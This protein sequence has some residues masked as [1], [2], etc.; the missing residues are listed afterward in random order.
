TSSSLL[1]MIGLSY[2]EFLLS[3]MEDIEQ[4]ESAL[5]FSVLHSRNELWPLL[6]TAQFYQI[7]NRVEAAH[8]YYR[9]ILS[10][11]PRDPS[12]FSSYGFF[13]LSQNKEEVL[14]MR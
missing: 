14:C 10:H 6:A 7:H 12:A 5:L 8:S 3:C 1:W 4:A 13:L 2:A 9:T 11:H